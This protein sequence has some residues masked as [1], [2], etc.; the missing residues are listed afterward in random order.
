MKPTMV[1][2]NSSSFCS[3]D[4]GPVSKRKRR[5]AIPTTKRYT[6]GDGRAR[7]C[8]THRLKKSQILVGGAVISLFGF[9]IFR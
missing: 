2:S 4:K 1:V 7:F 5:T 9:P 3:L 6:S 8:G